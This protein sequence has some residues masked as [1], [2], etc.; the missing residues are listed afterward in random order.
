MSL[1]TDTLP[2]GWHM[3]R[4]GAISNITMGQSPPSEEYNSDGKGLP[5]LQ[6]KADFTE[7]SP[8]PTKYCTRPLKVARQGSVLIS[9]R[10]PVGDVNLADRDYII[11]RGL[12]SISLREGDNH[13]LF[14]LLLYCKERISSLGSGTTFQQINRTTLDNFP[15]QLPSLPEQRAIAHALR[16][17]QEAKGARRRELAL[18][19]ERKAALMHHLF[20]HG[21]R[22]EPTKQTEIGEMPEGWEVVSIGDVATITSGGTPDRTKPEYWDGEIPWVKTGEINYNTITSTGERI[23]QEGLE[24]SSAKIIPAGTL[25]MAMYGQGVTRGRVALLGIDAAINQACAAMF[26]SERVSTAFLFQFLAYAY[27]R[28]R[29]LGHGANQR[30]LNAALI[31]SIPVALPLLPEQHEIASSLIA[32]DAKI[33]ALEREAALLGELFRAMLEEMMTGRVQAT[34]LMEV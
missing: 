26:L 33:A 31:R 17:V 4:L 28:I 8:S 15:I 27:E 18:E 25:L 3:A 5:F 30:N 7:F 24:N 32:C 9:V 14:Y 34:A 20:T 29:T 10:A 1:E 11:G 21:T 13:F 23:T 22:G 19:R 6:G 12:G 2:P 16:A